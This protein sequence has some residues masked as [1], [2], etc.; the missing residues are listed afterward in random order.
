[1]GTPGQPP[2]FPKFPCTL[3]K[4]G[5]GENLI[6]TDEG[7]SLGSVTCFWAATSKSMTLRPCF[8]PSL[9]DESAR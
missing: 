4:K 9:N 1:M 6:K 8:P 5:K 3:E 7:S 2:G